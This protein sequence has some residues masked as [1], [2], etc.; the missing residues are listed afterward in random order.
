MNIEKV[1]KFVKENKTEIIVGTIATAGMAALAVIGVKCRKPKLTDFTES[2]DPYFLDMCETVDKAAKGCT[3][4]VSMP[5]EELI[6]EID[7]ARFVDNKYLFEAPNKKLYEV[8][9]IIT[10]GNL[11][12]Q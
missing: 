1:K 9:N 12:E 7:N 11:V 10:F 2:L 4:Y 5:L 8:K 3:T 6:V